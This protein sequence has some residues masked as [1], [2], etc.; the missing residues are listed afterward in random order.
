MFAKKAAALFS[1]LMFAVPAF[2][3]PEAVKKEFEKKYP[4]VKVEKA[5]KAG[6]GDLWEIFANGEI[7]YTDEK[8]NFLM[9]GTLVEVASKKNI[10][11]ERLQR[12]TAIN[13]SELPLHHAI[14]LVR[15]DGSR[16]LAIF[17]DPNC[18]WCKRFEKDLNSLENITAYIFTY[19]ILSPESTDKAK[20]IWCSP[21]RLKAWQDLMLRDKAPTAKGTCAN[22][23]DQI[24]ALGQRLR[25]Q[26]TPMT[27]FEDG[28]RQ[29]GALSKDV[30]EARLAAAKAALKK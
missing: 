26:G 9:I 3:N 27:Y 10:T 22:P 1:L 19:P 17:E 23:V 28:E 18:G 25:V 24:A 8:V 30:L 11:E 13:F 15:G 5:T 21:D 14:K 6:Y 7:L 12:L 2:A 16:K 29:S 4:E 20:A